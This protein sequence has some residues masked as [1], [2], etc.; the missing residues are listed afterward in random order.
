MAD[1][2]ILIE[3]DGRIII[4]LN[5]DVS[6]LL[7]YAVSPFGPCESCFRGVARVVLPSWRQLFKIAS[8]S[9]DFF[10]A[11]SFIHSYSSSSWGPF[12]TPALS[13]AFLCRPLYYTLHGGSL[14]FG[15]HIVGPCGLRDLPFSIAGCRTGNGGK[16]SN[17]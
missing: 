17:S 16:V 5:N 12:F 1:R 3:I 9:G 15:S 4:L 2:S 10:F 11:P 14:F 13:L 7:S 6:L 8:P